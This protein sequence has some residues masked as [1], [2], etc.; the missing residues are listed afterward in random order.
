M[1][2][3]RILSWKEF[4]MVRAFRGFTNTLIIGDL[5]A[6][7]TH[8]KY[9]EFTQRVRDM[10][11][12]ELAHFVGDVADNHHSSY[13]ESDPDGMA[14]GD[15]LFWTK[16]ELRHW[17]EEYKNA[18]VSIGN[19][20]AI[21]YRKAFSAGVSKKWLKDYS[22]VF[23]TPTWKYEEEFL[24]GGTLFT[25]GIGRKALQRA[26]DEGVNVVQGHYH[27][28]LYVQ[29]VPGRA[30]SRFAMQ[31]GCGIDHSS[32]AMAYGKNFRQPALGCGVLLNH[33]E[34]ALVIKM[35]KT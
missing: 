21:A 15:E 19:H 31:S 3:R 12:C 13:H 25:H 23:D 11:Q 20:D 33:G 16:R 2:T 1:K 14:A 27:T 17:H 8:P 29:W 28:D 24:V 32:Y 4:D 34:Q 10:F 9:L 26:R 18:T 5:H 6:P 30:A 35:H 22:E 7:F